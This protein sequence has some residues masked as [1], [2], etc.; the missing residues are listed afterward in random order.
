MRTY[1]LIIVAN[2]VVALTAAISAKFEAWGLVIFDA[3][4]WVTV[5]VL[6]IVATLEQGQQRTITVTILGKDKEETK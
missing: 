4:L 5:L 2:V 6:M 1:L 3:F